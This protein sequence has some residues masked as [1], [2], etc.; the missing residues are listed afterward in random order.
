MEN[1]FNLGIKFKAWKYRYFNSGKLT[2]FENWL[3]IWKRGKNLFKIKK[4]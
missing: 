2:N 4:N 1:D 3:K